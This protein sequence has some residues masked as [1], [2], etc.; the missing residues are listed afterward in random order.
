MSK[1]KTNL[2]TEVLENTE[3]I[4]NNSENTEVL[5]NNSEKKVKIELLC[6]VYTKDGLL[7]TGEVLE[8]SQEELKNFAESFYKKI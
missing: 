3:N 2:D 4:E 8:I 6:D 1:K 7:K 5:E